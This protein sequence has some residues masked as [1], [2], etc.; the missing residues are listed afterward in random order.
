LIFILD[1]YLA[2]H[3]SVFDTIDHAVQHIAS[4]EFPCL[5]ILADNY[6]GSLDDCVGRR[7]WAEPQ[8]IGTHVCDDG[9]NRQATFKSEIDFGVDRSFDNLIDLAGENIPCAD[10]QLRSP[11]KALLPDLM[12]RREGGARNRLMYCRNLC[13]RG[14]WF[15][16][17][18]IE[19]RQLVGVRRCIA[20]KTKV[21]PHETHKRR[22]PHRLR[23]LWIQAEWNYLISTWSIWNEK[24]PGS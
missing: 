14:F 22:S 4:A 11:L 1:N 8:C 16:L 7:S 21:S 12:L 9:N 17:Q 19:G 15:A 5:D 24:A 20:K 6:L 23:H 10:L 3:R 2:V 13:S 18:W